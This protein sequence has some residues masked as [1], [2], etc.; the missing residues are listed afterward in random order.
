MA[1]NRKGTDNFIQDEDRII[2]RPL[3]E[4]MHESIIPYAEYVIM[5]RALP[6]VEDGLKPVQRRILY[7]MYELGLTPDK[8]HRKSARIVG[9]TLGKYHPHGD[10]SIYDAMVR[11][12]QDF[13]MRGLLVDGHGNF[14]SI[15]GDTA[16]AMRY[17]EARLTPLAMEMLR[18]IDKETVKFNLNF[19]DTMKEPEMLPGRFPNLLVNGAT[20]IAVGMATNIPPHNLC[21]VLDAV[22]AQMEN[23]NISLDQLLTIVPGPDF[24]TG[25]IIIGQD[26]IRDAYETG[27][28]KFFVRAKV[29]VEKAPG[30]K[31]LLVITELPYQVNKATLLERIMKLSEERKGVLTGIADIRDES[32][33]QGIRA[34]IELKKDGDP[35]K[36]LNY[37]Y[38]YSDLQIS[39]GVNIV[40]I[41]DGKP[42]ELGLKSIL[43]Y[44]IRH[45]KDVVT[46]RTQYELE[47]AKAREHILEGLMIAT[48]NID[49]V[50]AIIRSSKNPKEARKKLMNRFMLTEIQGQ[51]I[52]DMRLQ[53]LTGLEISNLER[54]YKAIKK[55][56]RELE[57]ILSSERVLIGVIKKELLDVKKK[58]EAPRRTLIIE[59]AKEA[60][61]KAEDLMHVEDTVIT[62]TRNQDIK[63]VP[64]KSYNRSNRDVES[65]ET[66]DMDYIE[67]VE[68]SAT[69][70]RVLFFTDIGN[71]YILDGREIPEGKW[72]DKGVPLITLLT[73][74]EEGERPIAIISVKDFS[75]EEYI[76]FYT[77]QGMIKRT[78]LS[79][80]DAIKS[81][82]IACGLNKD[83]RVIGAQLTCGEKDS[84]IITAQGMS[85]RFHGGEVSAMGR[86]ARGVK[87]IRLKEDDFVVM[88]CEVDDEGEIIV[89]TDRGFTSRTILAD[90]RTQGR[91]GVGS[92]T[93]RFAKDGSNGRCL[94]SGFYV[95]E[96]YEIILQQKDG[97]TTRVDTESISIDQRD[98]VG[99]SVVLVIM[100]NEISTAYRNYTD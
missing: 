47:K 73:N 77:A 41:A 99:Q 65:V 27:K 69:D 14:G 75:K 93:I 95:K 91:G 64:V 31:K 88:G 26:G 58:Y 60:E 63:R 90:Y 59:D 43:D 71:C 51:A 15:D 96:P 36:I 79:E 53:K 68:K 78:P 22:I 54:E 66:R 8:P 16:A 20:G 67:F 3:E 61:I 50:I 49:E 21:E 29:E 84:M 1:S 39:Y 4:V 30:G 7:T 25:G 70:H 97:T 89:I 85:I 46:H 23:P 2:Q 72:R 40:A 55:Q 5:E 94:I 45:Q 17:T 98:G 76:Q 37:L 12:A 48:Q 33:R 6:R 35:D 10:T 57:K 34:V 24:P 92:R 19:D 74:L 9:D 62:M 56:I 11:M 81:K 87:A 42:R 52:L 32:D 13:N 86:T 18:D 38:K 28:G 44:Y 80:Y 83:D 100:D 82:I